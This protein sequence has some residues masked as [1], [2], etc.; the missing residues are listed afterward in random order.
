[1][2]VST[3]CT[4]QGCPIKDECERYLL[5]LRRKKDG[6]WMSP[7]DDYDRHPRVGE[8]GMDCPDFVAA[9]DGEAD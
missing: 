7:P 9:R 2:R 8:P 4:A 1:M 5:G 3:A 6:W